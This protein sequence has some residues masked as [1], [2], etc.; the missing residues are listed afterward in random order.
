MCSIL[1]SQENICIDKI[2]IDEKENEIRVYIRSTAKSAKCPCCG[3]KGFRKHSKYFRKPQDI[4]WGE[5][6]VRLVIEVR[7]F[8]CDNPRCKQKIFSERFLEIISPYA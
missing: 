4:P 1:P 8:F 3:K 2:A 5:V 6:R 7:K